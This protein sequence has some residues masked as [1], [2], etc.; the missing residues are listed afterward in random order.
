MSLK[1][2]AIILSLWSLMNMLPAIGVVVYVAV[3]DKIHP[4]LPMRFC[5]EEIDAIQ[6]T[7]LDTINGMAVF[8]NSHVFAL[9]LIVLIATWQGLAKGVR[10]VFWALL[11]SMSASVVA[12][13]VA[14]YV[15]QSHY[16]SPSIISAVLLAIGFGFTAVGLFKSADK[17]S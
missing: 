4:L 1:I 14:S 7:V 3:L 13:F 6:P 8:A 12:G 10:W 16:Y 2:G 5:G 15:D 17:S 9:C 11:A